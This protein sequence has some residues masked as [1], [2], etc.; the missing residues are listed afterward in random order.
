LSVEFS[1]FQLHD[2]PG[3]N[4][5]AGILT[6]LAPDH[7]DR[8]A[9]LEAY[10]ADKA[11]LFAKAG[12]ASV[13]VTNADNS[14]RDG[15]P[16]AGRQLRFSVA[17]RADG[18]SRSG[19]RTADARGRSLARDDFPLSVITTSLMPWRLRQVTAAA[20]PRRRWPTASAASRRS[21]TDW[22]PSA[23]PGCSDHRFQGDQRRVHHGRRCG[24]DRPFVLPS[25]P[26]QGRTPLRRLCS[27]AGPGR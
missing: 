17:G 6:N 5:V 24:M 2:C 3:I 10:Y 19:R 7:L 8:Y 9:A 20:F 13:W 16:L 18:W 26:A 15:P 11:G 22:S 4:P 25:G 12:A 27:P 14:P 23:A 1:S 21:P